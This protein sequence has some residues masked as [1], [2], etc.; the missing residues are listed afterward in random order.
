[1]ICNGAD[2]GILA[3]AHLATEQF[4]EVAHHVTSND[5]V[6]ARTIW[7]SLRDFIPRL[8][9]EVNPMPINPFARVPPP[10]VIN[11]PRAYTRTRLLDR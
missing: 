8:F 10:T 1:M 6:V 9:R 3:A 2:G 5:H 11:L 7:S 4:V